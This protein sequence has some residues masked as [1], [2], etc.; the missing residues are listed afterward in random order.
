MLGLNSSCNSLAYWKE[1]V[2]EIYERLLEVEWI[3][4][5]HNHCISPYYGKCLENLWILAKS[6]P[7]IYF[8]TSIV[9][10]PFHTIWIVNFF[11]VFMRTLLYV[12]C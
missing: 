8:H 3:L 4:L 2:R 5:F 6:I 12:N 11:L 10:I 1:I 9:K 7:Y